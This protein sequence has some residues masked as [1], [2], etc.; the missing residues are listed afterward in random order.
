MWCASQ[1]TA[2]ARLAEMV[3]CGGGAG[4]LCVSQTCAFKPSP[5]SLWQEG[6]H[7]A[8][9]L[10]M[11][12]AARDTFF[13]LLTEWLP[14]R[15]YTQ[16]YQGSRDGMTPRAFHAACD[17]KGPTLTLVRSE[18]GHCFGGYAG[19]PW[20]SGLRWLW[21]KKPHSLACPQAFLFSV[22]IPSHRGPT[23]FPS[24]PANGDEV[25]FCWGECG[26]S[27]NDGFMLRNHDAKADVP[28]D[29]SSFCGIRADG[30][31]AD[32]LGLGAG[33]FTQSY[34]FMPEEVEVF[35]VSTK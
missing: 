27:F 21:W 32:T 28:F 34:N 4:G 3:R 17:G 16:L 7:T 13:R 20:D 18:H 9:L 33:T 29:A 6:P 35:L 19:V 24:L 31:F 11:P 30:M 26:P 25:V 12:D 22:G 23:L 5:L 1:A 8:S 14:G 2:E 10:R 15:R